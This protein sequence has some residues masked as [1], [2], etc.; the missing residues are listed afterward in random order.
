MFAL[1][2]VKIYDFENYIDNGYIVFDDKIVEVGDM[3]AFKDRGYEI[4]DGCGHVAMPSLTVAHSHIYSAFSRGMKLDA[5]PSNFMEILEQIWW[6][7]DSKLTLDDVYLSGIV[8]SVEFAKHGVTAVIDHH[9]GAGIIG[10]LDMLQKAVHRDTGLRGLFCF[11]TSDRFNV[12]DCIEEN[13]RSADMFGLHASMTLSDDTLKRVKKVLGNKPI[14]IHAAESWMD[15]ENCI[16]YHGKR[17]IERLNDFGLL[18]K[19]SILAHCIHINEREAELIAKNDC[20]VALN[21]RSNM[22]NAVGLPDYRLMKEKGVKCLIGNDGMSTGIMSE[23]TALNL[24][25][26]HRYSAS[27]TFGMENLLEI[28]NNNYDYISKMMGIRIG[29]LKEGYNADLLSV[30]YNPPTPMNKTN[31]F[32]HLMYGMA[33]N[34]TPEHVWCNGKQIVKHYEVGKELDLKFLEARKAATKLWERIN[35]N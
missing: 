19:N 29:R 3:I 25:M 24:A 10:S 4:S 6:K 16:S 27:S 21:I 18:N 17:V 28:I 9:A 30:E 22:N 34:F 15:Q 2:N 31:A 23:W 33:E 35:G 32:A 26:K 14:H 13:S 7:L 20:Y 8:S 5:N 11:E 1:I 12:N